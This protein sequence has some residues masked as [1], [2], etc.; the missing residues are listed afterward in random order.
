G[1]ARQVVA[2]D[3][4]DGDDAALAER[5]G[6][7]PDRIRCG[8]QGPAW[9]VE[10]QPGT[11]GRAHNAFRVKSAIAGI[12][13]L[14]PAAGAHDEARHR[15]ALAVVGERAHHGEPWSAR[16]ARQQRVA[17]ASI[18]RVG[19][20]AQTRLAHRQV[21]HREQPGLAV[22]DA[23]ADG[24]RVAGASRLVPDDGDAVAL[25]GGSR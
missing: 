10:A 4:L 7:S 20:L 24:D 22:A 17:V 16:R 13:V 8:Y 21:G 15:R 11:A 12:V 18:M 19:Q 14:A 9:T 6:G 1:I 23:A 25:D 5:R 2:A 3:A